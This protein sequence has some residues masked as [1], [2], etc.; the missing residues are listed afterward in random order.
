[1]SRRL[2]DDPLT[3][4]RDER[5]RSQPTAVLET[6]AAQRSSAS[7][8]EVFFERRSR[9]EEEVAPVVSEPAPEISEISELPEMR[10][11]ETVPAVEPQTAHISTIAEVVAQLNAAAPVAIQ[12][13]TAPAPAVTL[14]STTAAETPAG[15]DAEATQGG[16]FFKRLFGKF[17]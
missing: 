9:E 15:S 6:G 3:R 7:Y 13:E 1:L 5:A 10:E 14:A 16:G 12:P 11:V 17:K 8:N 4:A 2:G